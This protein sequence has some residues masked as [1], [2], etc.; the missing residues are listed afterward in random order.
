VLAEY[1]VETAA[2]D[3]VLNSKVMVFVGRKGTGKT[4]NLLRAGEILEDDRRRLVSII[5]P[6]GYE[7]EAVVRL[8]ER[9]PSPD[10]QDYVV[11][12]L[13]KYLL[14]S[15]IA[16]TAA[17]EI[18]RR[19]ASPDAGSP[20][21]E[22]LE[23]LDGPGSTLALDFAVRLERA[24]ETL[25][26]LPT[27]A[28]IEDERA[29]ITEALHGKPIRDLRRL[30]GRLLERRTQV[31]VLID[32]LDKPWDRSTNLD[33]LSTFLLGLLTAVGR[34]ESDFAREDSWRRPV[35]LTLGVFLRS[36]IFA[37]VLRVAREPDKIPFIRLA[38]D[39]P[40]LLLRV[41]D[42]RYNAAREQA[43]TEGELWSKYFT[44]RVRGIETRD[45]ILKR[46]L[47]RPRDIVYFCNAAI[48]TAVNRRHTRIE[49]D[50]IFEAERIY[51]Q[52]SFEALLVEERVV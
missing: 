22:L 6:F 33:V 4:A 21:A 44:S 25:L 16:L 11:E 29:R 47:P 48:T 37:R 39:D 14:L 1:F 27:Q 26:D 40:E 13:W 19:P 50:D 46:I 35:P 30:L 7:L 9:F 49:E 43:A 41:V 23:Y 12:A 34:L 17:A 45:Y 42:E 20:E 38:W 52:F 10:A 2:F 51:S 8:L 31:A 18:E 15:E 5:K 36:D 28:R 24:I 32:N 3:E